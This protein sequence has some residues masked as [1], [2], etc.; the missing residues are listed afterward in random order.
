MDNVFLSVQLHIYNNEEENSKRSCNILK[1]K[2]A[3]FNAHS[4]P[5]NLKKSGKKTREI[6]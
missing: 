4:G 1:Y 5:E 2:I 6:K 3:C